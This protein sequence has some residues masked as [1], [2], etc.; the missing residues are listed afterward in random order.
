MKLS[1]EMTNIE[2]AEL[3][4]SVAASYEIKNVQNSK[5]RIIAYE[6]AADAIEHLSSEAKD[7]WDDGKLDDVAGIGPSISQYLGEIFSIGKSKHFEN[8]LSNIPP[9]VFEL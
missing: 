3:L 8:I 9:A 6:K 1:K 4:R 7:L 2:I 5:F